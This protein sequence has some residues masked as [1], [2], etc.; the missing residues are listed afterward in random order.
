MA[1]RE[2]DPKSETKASR[3]DFYDY[4][5]ASIPFLKALLWPLIV[6]TF[7]IAFLSPIREVIYQLPNLVTRA[8]R[9]TV[10]DLTFEIERRLRLDPPP[11][12]ARALPSLPRDAIGLLLNYGTDQPI[13]RARAPTDT[14]SE[15]IQHYP[16]IED[17]RDAN[18]VVIEWRLSDWGT[19][20]QEMWM[21][22]LTDLGIEAH[23]Y[24]IDVL[25]E[26]FAES[27]SGLSSTSTP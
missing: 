11:D 14:Y 9:V 2:K 6:A 10:G 17:L 8:S 18:L 5:V 20:S 1:P 3:R 24:I 19:S 22:S 27:Y 7:I 15:F 4:Y 12:L 21:W 25:V 23:K 16:G 26:V 13:W